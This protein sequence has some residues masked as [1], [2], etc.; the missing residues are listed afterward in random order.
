MVISTQTQPRT[1]TATFSYFQLQPRHEFEKPYEILI[2]LPE[3]AKHVPR[4]N[5]SFEDAECIVEDV[6]GREADFSLD[7]NGFMWRQSDTRVEDFGDRE[8]IENVYLKEVE[9]FLRGILGNDV[10]KV[11]VFDWRVSYLVI[12]SFQ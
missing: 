6:R 1:Q 9:E 12:I 2:D 7:A 3:E 8:Q 10:R 5:L 11:K 4:S